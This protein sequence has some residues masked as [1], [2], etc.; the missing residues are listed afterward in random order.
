M[1]EDDLLLIVGEERRVWLEYGG[2]GVV[3]VAAGRTA[4]YDEW[5]SGL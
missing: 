1:L 5:D 3:V 2:D 4:F